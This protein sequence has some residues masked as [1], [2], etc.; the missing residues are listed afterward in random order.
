[1]EK[2]P[3]I[4]DLAIYKRQ[5]LLLDKFNNPKLYHSE[6]VFKRYLSTKGSQPTQIALLHVP[7]RN[8]KHMRNSV[9]DIA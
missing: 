7:S 3:S 2:T 4:K 6:I 8:I 9:F 5:F 1:M